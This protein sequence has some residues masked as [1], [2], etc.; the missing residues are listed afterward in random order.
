MTVGLLSVW[1]NG[2]DMV[3]MNLSGLGEGG[4]GFRNQVLEIDLRAKHRVVG[5]GEVPP[6][7]G[8]PAHP[9]SDLKSHA[10]FAARPPL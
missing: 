10:K 9:V 6:E 3:M 4:G 8:C 2:G 5:A 1:L 7:A